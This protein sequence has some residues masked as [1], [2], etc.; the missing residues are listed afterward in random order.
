MGSFLD[1][2]NSESFRKKLIIRN[3][4]PYSKSPNQPNLPLN[5]EYKQSDLP[6]IDSPDALID[7]PTFANSLYPLNQWGNEGGYEQV[8][9]V[10]ALKN[11]KS[12]QGEYGPGQQDAKILSQ[13]LPESKNWK[14]LNA[15]SSGSDQIIDSGE[16]IS[17]LDYVTTSGVYNNQPYPNFVNSMYRPVSILLNTDPLGD[18][19]LLSQ[20]SFIAK[21]GATT[22]RKEFQDRIAAQIRQQTVD[23]A[24][25]FNVDSGA[26]ALGL[27]TG[28]IPLIEPNW[29]ITQPSNPVLAA[30]DF[31]LRL[32][33]SILP[34]SPIPGSYFDPSINSKQPVTGA[35]LSLAYR[36]GVLGYLGS[37]ILSPTQTGSQIFYNN[38][39]GGQK[40]RLFANIDYNKYKPSFDRT[41]FDRLGGAIVG[42]TTDNGAYYIGSINSEPSR[43]FSPS[44]E[45]PINEVGQEIQTIVYGPSEL[46]KLYEG[47]SQD[48]KLGAN[49]PTYSDGGGIEGGLTWVSPK[50]RNNAG[51]RVGPNGVI[52]DQDENFRPY[53]F[54]STESTDREFRSGSILDETQRIINSQP[55]GGKRLQH[56]GN[57]IDQVSKVF[58]DGY[59]E[60]TKGSKVLSY[61]GA[62]GQEVG[63]EYC[64]IFSKDIPYL[65]Y[66]NLQKT[67]GIV[68]EG[69]RFSWSV[70]DKTYNLNIVPNKQEGGKDSSNIIGNIS[71]DNGIAKKYMF[72]LENL[73]WRTSNRPGF[74]YADLPVCERGPNG[75]RVMW[76]PP[77]GLSFSESSTPQFKAQ[78]FIGRPEPI[79]TYSNTTRS[80]TLSWKIVVDHPSILN[81]ITNKVLNNETNKARVD[82]ILESFF[83]GCRKY[84][85][86]ELAKKYTNVKPDDLKLIQKALSDKTVTTNQIET[87]ITTITTGVD[88]TNNQSQIV[89]SNINENLFDEF[90]N[91]GVYF[92]NDYPKQNN[93]T[94]Y[95]N[96]YDLYIANKSFY[97]QK[98]NKTSSFF[99]SVI[100]PNFEKMNEL[101][102]K[103]SELFEKNTGNVTIYVKSSCSAPATK[104]YN[105]ELG[106]RRVQSL[107]EFFENNEKVKKYINQR[108][109]IK[110]DNDPNSSGE[111]SSV[112]LFKDGRFDP[113]I[114]VNCSDNDVN[115]VGGDT[116][117]GSKDI[118]TTNAM[119]CR[120]AYISNV[121]STLQEPVT[122]KPKTQQIPVETKVTTT[123]TTPVLEDQIINRNNITKYVVR[124][125]LSE[126][127][128]FETVKE[129]TPMIYDNLKDKLKFFQPG[130]HSMTPE[131]LNARLTFLQ[132]C[133][134]PG[135][136]IPTVKNVQGNEILE[137]NNATNTAFGSP[138]VLVLRIGDFYNTKI[139]PTSLNIKYDDTL[140]L[141]PEGIGVQPMIAEVTLGF[142]F[143]GG[144]GL[145]TSIDKLQNALSFN[146][147]A[148]TEIYDD[149]S[150]STDTESLKV[151]DAE[152]LA[153]I[154]TP[155]PPTAN[156]S[157][158]NA[159]KSN[160]STIGSITEKTLNDFETGFINYSD[161]MER[162]KNETQTYFQTVVG[163]N[164]EITLQYNNAIRQIW[165]NERNYIKGRLYDSNSDFI[166]FGKPVNFAK[167]I[168][169]ISSQFIKDIDDDLENFIIFVSKKEKNFSTKLIR[170][171]KKN[172]TNYIKSKANTYQNGITSIVQSLVN[173]EQSYINNLAQLN[174]ILYRG[175]IGVPR[176]TDGYQ[177]KNGF[178]VVY[179]ISGT[180]EIDSTSTDVTNTYDELTKDAIKIRES[181][182]NYN[183]ITNASNSFTYSVDKKEYS[184]KLIYEVSTSTGKNVV[185][186]NDPNYVFAPFCQKILNIGNNQTISFDNPEFK[187]AYMFL[188]DDI[189]DD[190][191][192]EQFKNRLIGNIKNNK[193]I[194]GGSNYA[195]NIEYVFDEYWKN[196][197]KQ[198]FQ[199]ETNITNEFINNMESE[200]LKD[201]LNFTP[202]SKKKR[203]FTFT[204]EPLPDENIVKGQKE[205]IVGLGSTQNI[206]TDNLKWNTN[207]NTS[208]PD[209]LISKAK[210]N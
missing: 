40:S 149:R 46:A 96:Q 23:R 179:N 146:F 17:Q 194:I 64:R 170:Q 47:P 58:N 145:K 131:G 157:N 7:L 29:T 143:V 138:P 67:D 118:Y 50:Y 158:I 27:L 192:Y 162:I 77:Y 89:A 9:D 202:F 90:K 200:K 123:I 73:A 102:N 117:V 130:F 206:D 71:A 93:V 142:N 99:E 54:D 25:I 195:E 106:E 109:F 110:S 205:L 203:N 32:G 37:K 80:G 18:N 165:Q 26:D 121:V 150:D 196:K 134:R 8:Q 91:I 175:G 28:R 160:G 163:K 97:E 1:L 35:Q 45:L 164:K 104:K 111:E 56:V 100:T 128:Y 178:V 19:G 112:M 174:T 52:L 59:K 6:V 83:A 124:M 173:Q 188:S 31:I 61:V 82:S 63:T 81:V 186:S 161:F 60:I 176:G 69:R 98:N 168:D 115:I 33:G 107:I 79:Y 76:F 147:Y 198:L 15:F 153:L 135:D 51:K 43:V 30:T 34:V 126:C 183:A 94:Q 207:T 199:E 210:L 78:D 20:D 48:I 167:K 14:K 12:N 72:S 21:L 169:I 68:T 16:F 65:Q 103:L 113:F 75:G 70:L 120:R 86:Y 10:N 159:G 204:S 208:N 2:I 66:N 191:K 140:D 180:T 85:I 116:N 39:G 119:A 197:A 42:T 4:K 53:S 132:Q 137:Y 144:S 92:E 55:Q 11:T 148:N 41:I 187:R 154:N 193:T 172:Y 185:D 74:T 13:A 108:L 49:G 151:L 88:S 133:T 127:D 125:L 182:V 22:L 171:L 156:Q 95:V 38:T 36:G 57:A 177:Q 84:D 184:G 209:V 44:G 101:C 201:F 114:K 166:L 139:I 152:F 3:L 190:K 155:A 24:N 189:L 5:Y 122:E 181:V 136:T 141:N 129:E 105:V 87:I 62:I